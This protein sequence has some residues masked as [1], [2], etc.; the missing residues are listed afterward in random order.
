MR[1]I[2]LFH[3]YQDVNLGNFRETIFSTFFLL[4]W[5]LEH[6][7]TPGLIKM[8]F[9]PPLGLVLIKKQNMSVM[10]INFRSLI[11]GE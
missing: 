11:G 1:T 6:A 4:N 9:N 5:V 10:L 3:W 2:L 7:E 8:Q